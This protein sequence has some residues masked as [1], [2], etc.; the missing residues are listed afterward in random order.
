MFVTQPTKST[1]LVDLVGW[2]I[3]AGKPTNQLDW[4]GWLGA[5]PVNQVTLPTL[6]NQP[7]QPTKFGN[8][9]GWFPV[10]QLGW[11]NTNREPASFQ[12]PTNQTNQPYKLGWFSKLVGQS[13]WFFTTESMSDILIKIFKFLFSKHFQKFASVLRKTEKGLHPEH[14]GVRKFWNLKF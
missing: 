14:P 10:G 12:K 9:V 4:L 7:N 3:R 6:T 8:L 5:N 2:A 1:K 11:R 13:G